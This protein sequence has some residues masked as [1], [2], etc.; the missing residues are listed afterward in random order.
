MIINVYANETMIRRHALAAFLSNC[1]IAYT[2][3]INNYGVSFMI[4]SISPQ[5]NVSFFNSFIFMMD[6]MVVQ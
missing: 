1:V 4:T 5:C 3:G 6:A 2:L